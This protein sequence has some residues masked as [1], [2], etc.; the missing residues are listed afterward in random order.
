MG[1]IEQ[2]GLFFKDLSR[3]GKLDKYEDWRLSPEER[4]KDLASK[5]TVEQMAGLMLYSR[6]QSIPA[7]SNGWFSG[8]YGGKTY[9]ESGAKPWELTDEQI[10]FLV[11]DHVRHVLVTTVESPEVARAGTTKYRRLL[12]V[13][14]SVFRRTTAPIPATLRFKLRIQRGCGRSYLHV[15]R[16]AG[17]GRDLRS[18]DHEG[19]RE[20]RFQ[21]YRALGLATALSPQIDIATEPRWFRYNGTFGEDSKLADMARAYVDGF[22][23]SEGER[24]IAD[25]WGMTASMRW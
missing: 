21:E 1:L 2:D 24:E 18:R 6:H 12:R 20:D 7:L 15:A 19:V 4:A 23:A 13:P 5:M 8:T 3:D 14:V 11:K 25:G 16:D 10:A 17:L 22:Q 9:E